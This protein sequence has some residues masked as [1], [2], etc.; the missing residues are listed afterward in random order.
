MKY[1]TVKKWDPVRGFGFI[2]SDDDEDLFVHVNDLDPRVRSGGLEE[3][4]RV[5]FDVR[6]EVKGDRAINVRVIGKGREE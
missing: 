4:Q 5:A 3:G 6:R 2:L 1:G